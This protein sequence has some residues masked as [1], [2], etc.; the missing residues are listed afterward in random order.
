[1]LT[2]KALS[3]KILECFC[4]CMMLSSMYSASVEVFSLG[5]FAFLSVPRCEVLAPLVGIP[6]CFDFNLFYTPSTDCFLE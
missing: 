5:F 3:S 6:C 2:G 1:V 4:C